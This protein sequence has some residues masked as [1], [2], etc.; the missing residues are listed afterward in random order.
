MPLG[1]R[2]H[3]PSSLRG[4]TPLR[5][6]RVRVWD[7][8]TTHPAAPARDGRAGPAGR[9]RRPL[10][11]GAWRGGV[12]EGSC[13]VTVPAARPSPRPPAP[14]DPHEWGPPPCRGRRGL[15][16]AVSVR[17]LEDVPAPEVC[18]SSS[19]VRILLSL[20]AVPRGGRPR[21]QWLP[22]CPAQAVLRVG[23]PTPPLPGGAGRS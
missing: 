1:S 14:Q 12:R 9:C 15:C 22:A 19:A 6:L 20:E 18:A 3:H 23:S 2:C 17:K 5:V 21:A 7:V 16:F 11:P 13:F 8:R 4:R 10:Q